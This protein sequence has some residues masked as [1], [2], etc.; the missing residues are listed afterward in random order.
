MGVV[1]LG[2][3]QLDELRIDHTITVDPYTGAARLRIPVP[4]PEGRASFGPAL[5]LE[6]AAGS[7]GAPFA[8]GWSLTGL[9]TIEIDTRHGVPRWDG[10]D[11]FQLGGAELVPWLERVG[12]DWRPRT[13]VEGGFQITFYRLRTAGAAIRVERWT[14]IASGQVHF[15]ARDAQNVLTIFGARPNAAARICDPADEHR[16]F[17]WLPELKL[18]PDGN[19]IWI[20]YAAEDLVGVDRSLSFERRP[21][22]TAQRY[23][24]RIRYGN[25]QPLEL[26]PDVVA[27]TMPAD[28]RWAFQVVFDYGDHHGDDPAAV[29][30]R[31]WSVRVDPSSNHRPGFDVRTYRLCARILAFHDLPELGATPTLV[32]QLVLDNEPA[33]DGTTLRRVRRIGHRSDPSGATTAS[34]PP[35]EMTY[36]PS[37]VATGF[38]APPPV[39]QVNMPAGLTG[40]RAAFVDLFG[41]GLPGLLAETDVA[42]YWKPNL[43]GGEFGQQMLLL[44]K[45]AARATS[46]AFGDHD[47]DGDTDYAQLAGRLAGFFEFDRG[48]GR[49]QSFRPF[50]SLPHVEALGGRA[51]WVDLNGD[52]RVDIIVAAADHFVWYP[53]DGDGFGAPIEVPR[54]PGMP[55]LVDDPALDFF[56]ADMTGD[57]LADL[58]RVQNGRVE[59][60]ANQGGGRFAEPVVFENSPQFDA[61]GQFDASR[62]RFVDLD[63]SGSMDL[64]YLGR[65]E[66]R[67]WINAA[68]NRLVP[69]PRI[70]GLPFIDRLSTARVLDFL[71]DGRPCLVW[72][73][74]TPGDASPIEY[75]PLAPAVRPRLLVRV[76]D[77]MGR[78]TRLTY[79]SSS[80]H[81]LRDQARGRP[82]STKLPGHVV[83]VETR[84]DIDH[85]SGTQTTTRF[86]YHDGV[87]D[88][89]ER[90]FRGFG[91][92]DV[93]DAAVS[94]DALGATP[95]L[96]RTWFHQGVPMWNQHRSIDTYDDAEL[97]VLPSDVVAGELAPG[98]YED[99]LRALA[100]QVIRREVFAVDQ[101]GARAAHP[102]VVEQFCQRVNRA[103]PR[104]GGAR[105]AFVI[106]AEESLVAS[107]EGVGGDPRVQ[108]QVAI[109]ADEYGQITRD[110]T[111]AYPRRSSVVRDV[112]AQGALH[113]VIREH[114]LV[115]VDND[116]RFAL[117]VPIEGREYELAGFAE[118]VERITRERLREQD[119]VD[120]L[121]A[122][123]RHDEDIS[124]ATTVTARLLAWDQQYYWNDA[125]TGALPLGSIGQRV[126]VHHEESAVFSPQLVADVFG[127]RVAP[128]HIAALGYTLRDGL[129]WQADDT[130]LWGVGGFDLSAGIEHGGATATRFAYDPHHLV[131]VS[132][133]DARGLQTIGELDYNVLE[134]WRI[135]DPNGAVTEVRYDALGV[136]T[137]TTRH[138]KVESQ[139]WGMEP[140]AAHTHRVPADVDALLADPD[141]YLQGAATFA[142]YDLE[143]W[144]RDR[145]PPY[146]A[147][148]VR[149][150]LRHDGSGGAAA[151]SRVAITIAHFDGMGRVL[152]QKLRVDAGPAVQRDGAGKVLVGG[153]GLPV[154]GLA[155]ERWRASGHTVF[156]SKQ[157]PARTFEPFFT[158]TWQYE[159]DSELREFGVATTTLYDAV[160]RQVARLFP[161]GTFERTQFGPWSITRSDANDTV[162][163]STYRLLREGRPADDPERQ[164][165]EHARAHRE[166]STVVYLDSRGLEVGT[167]VRG[168]AT[169]DR[170][171][172]S[173]LDAQGALLA[174]IDARG[175][176][177]FTYRRDMQGRVLFTH[178][179]DAG[180]TWTLH[181]AHDRVA[182][183][184]DARGFAV[185]QTYDELDRPVAV[186][187]RGNG[188]DH[189]VEERVYGDDLADPV[190]AR[191]RNLLGRLAVVRDHAGVAT[192]IAA[193]PD[194]RPIRS[195][196]QLRRDMSEPDWRQATPLGETFTTH[197]RFDALGRVVESQLADGSIQTTQYHRDGGVARCSLTTPGGTANDLTDA[198]VIAET[199]HDAHGR[200][201]RLVLGNGVEVEYE[202]DRETSRLIGQRAVRGTRTYQN[203]SYTWDPVG[204][205]VRLHDRAHDPGPNSVVGGAAVG[206]RRDF[207]YDAHYRLV[208]ATGRVHQAL[209]E[210]DYIPASTGAVHHSRHLSLNNGAA[211]E[212]YTRTYAYDAAGNLHTIRHTG[213]TRS[214]TTSL[215]VSS[216]SNRALGAVD[217]NGSPVSKPESRF[218]AAGH[219]LRMDHLRD[220][221]WSWR[222]TLD[223]AVVIERAD[224]NN[225]NE[226]Y[227]YD[228]NNRRVR[229]LTH[230]V[231]HGGGSETIEKVYLG[232]CERKQVRRGDSVIL[233]RW[234]IHVED[235]AGRVAVVHRWTTDTTGRETPDTSRPRIR[236]QLT[237]HQS[238]V[239][240]ELDEVG[241]LLSYEE[242]FPYG[243]TAFIAGDTVR[244]ASKEYRYTGKERD[245]ATSL[246]YYGFRYYAPWVGRWLSPDPIGP[247]DALNLYQFVLGDPI[248]SVDR[249]GLQTTG[250]QIIDVDQDPPPGYFPTGIT[251]PRGKLLGFNRATGAWETHT[252]AEWEAIGRATG[253]NY[254]NFRG[255]SQGSAGGRGGRGGRD[256]GVGSGTRSRGSRRRGTGAG[257]GGTGS[258]G[259]R[260]RGRGTTGGGTGTSTGRRGRDRRTQ[261]GIDSTGSGNTSGGTGGDGGTTDS[262]GGDGSG[263]EG[264]GA[265]GTGAEG[266]GSGSGNQGTGPGAQGA[267]AG[268]DAAGDGAGGD[269]AGD[270]QGDGTGLGSGTGDGN[271]TT[272]SPGVG[273][274]NTQGSGDRGRGDGDGERGRDGAGGDATRGRGAPGG[275]R[276]GT[277]TNGTGRPGTGRPTHAGTTRPSGTGTNTGGTTDP[278]LAPSATGQPAPP[279]TT[280]QGTDPTAPPAPPQATTTSGRPGGQP[281]GNPNGSREGTQ[282]TAQGGSSGGRLDGDP[283]YRRGAWDT[284]VRIAG[285]VHGEF[286]D[287]SRRGQR[288]GVPGGR[289]SWNL[290]WFGQALY[291]AAAIASIVSLA[292]LARSLLRNGLRLFLRRGLAHLR[293]V[294]RPR[295]FLTRLRRFFWDPR[296]FNT[297]SREYWGRFRGLGGAAGGS[298]HHW[299]IPQR[300]G[301]VPQGIRNAGF[302]LLVLNGRLNTWMGFAARWGGARAAAAHVIENGI[303][304]LVPAGAAGAGYAGYRW[305]QE[306]VGGADPQPA[307]PARGEAGQ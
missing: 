191:S 259:R 175:L 249:D 137:V 283:T 223:E 10:S 128:S 72:S 303:R 44:E 190:D 215:W 185:E 288:G 87:Y 186:H 179:I 109:E 219:L 34:I 183:T 156:D 8:A 159:A 9:P 141:F 177:A 290:G 131:I 115:N 151:S 208:Q 81:Y 51:Q 178:S 241:E 201:R 226:R 24:K 60:W 160:G 43:G 11:G 278:N 95:A 194:G 149:E 40:R 206:A 35:L 225:D 171:N 217:P 255:G 121:A 203:V 228:A 279:G 91:H 48:E 143:A 257:T 222:G 29:P 224:G 96:T 14:E 272:T 103:Q 173:R 147:T 269:G 172:E 164:A 25:H 85:I 152:Q 216:T 144:T 234:T 252:R 4:V 30:D 210:R 307:S 293:A 17:A 111:I 88:G 116:D 89:D 114:S 80:A 16:T 83:V 287:E 3:R 36:A 301:W 254:F 170:R 21:P 271:G 120:A 47:R 168:G 82:W 233:E 106:T 78:E 61:D 211:I 302:N 174:S 189:R 200:R 221:V 110:A 292:G 1:E 146:L 108:A 230:R 130:Q 240:L 19:A 286:G 235:G 167:L 112:E 52:G 13:R 45:P 18:A 33:E 55:P 246:Y 227:S 104:H 113:V 69:G 306:L 57:G 263:G 92:V 153:D 182:A 41:D 28:M 124:T 107:Y 136:V 140:L 237:T 71:G 214:W 280:T 38:V 266:E 66:V 284:V 304:V 23:L 154:M 90:S 101:H 93:Y 297:I 5:A 184:W 27:G 138:G 166:T 162:E 46:F 232:G 207:V 62:L 53:S 32:S 31:A 99:A 229:K 117:G 15:R 274:G 264:N 204:N 50:S 7:W 277:G 94:T 139:P 132:T 59:Y 276:G 243:G 125:R 129:W 68:G 273:S 299:L 294:F 244:I 2:G 119:V 58:V 291:V 20:D 74:T 134:P 63:G 67:T 123:R 158:T 56:F 267:E 84:D 126:L 54:P 209:L 296:Q 213:A 261:T 157:Q 212:R 236:Y 100:G 270:G 193:D 205:L 73:S 251:I 239:A 300:W 70:P 65:G 218:D 102:I 275:V 161:N 37:A 145:R 135:T 265:G 77:S 39:S 165:Y 148:L 188:L 12:G 202:Y 64:V 163:E 262:S 75:L 122:P 260:Q 282:T 281:G 98:D 150:G 198:A 258:R 242:F 155:T 169:H 192:T 142:F 305:G 133:T 105:A 289:G 248:G 256:R 42:W 180:D 245:G 247:V 22:A 118:P 220:L 197:T 187:V 195:S 196:L 97:P 76:E 285:Y 86:E 250:G 26:A 176:V 238:S 49:W 268:N 127:S 231:V 295:G 6:Y 79:A 181:D 298:L 253:V 199:A